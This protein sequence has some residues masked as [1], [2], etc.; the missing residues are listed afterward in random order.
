[1]QQE[2]V[3]FDLDGTLAN[4]GPDLVA[5]LNMM[6]QERDLPPVKF[7]EVKY[8]VGY[9]SRRLMRE[10]LINE[11][12]DLEILRKQFLSEYDRIAHENSQLFK[13]IPHVLDYLDNNSIPWAIVTNKPTKQT[14]S[15]IKKFNLEHRISQLVCSDTL[16]KYKPDPDGIIHVCNKLNIEPRNG[17]YIGDTT[18]DEDAANACGMP[19][20]AA[21]WGYW[22]PD[23]NTKFLLQEP[24]EILDYLR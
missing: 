3:L 1:M 4:T 6:R 17:V 5:A 9:G 23:L 2:A 11:G 24:Q 8:V 7:D 18:I 15:F 14:L 20:L 19:F 13:G 10:Y 21:G 12:E 22:Q 16:P